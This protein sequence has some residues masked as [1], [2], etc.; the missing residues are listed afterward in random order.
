ML[1]NTSEKRPA[2]E[3]SRFLLPFSGTL[4]LDMIVP[5]GAIL[6]SGAVIILAS[7]FCWSCDVICEL[8]QTL[9]Q[10]FVYCCVSFI[11]IAGIYYGL[12]EVRI[13]KQIAFLFLWERS[14][15]YS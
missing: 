10:T 2:D 1:L 7:S 14:K 13:S 15:M 11:A 12:S 8:V 6:L 4:W 3:H 5:M 9:L